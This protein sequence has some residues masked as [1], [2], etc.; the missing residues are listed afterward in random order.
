MEQKRYE[1]GDKIFVQAPLVLGQWKQLL[2]LLKTVNLS[3]EGGV[4]RI[5]NELGPS[6]PRALAIVLTEE[7]KSPREKDLD[8]LADELMFLITPETVIDVLADFFVC[9]PIPSMLDRFG[10]MVGSIG[11]IAA[12]MK[13]M[14]SNNTSAS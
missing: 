14:S 10:G 7:G 2:D 11:S 8:A 5:A 4:A 3:L 12:Q 13:Q 6:L 1:I 9:N